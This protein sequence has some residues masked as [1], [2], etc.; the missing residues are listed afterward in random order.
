MSSP[1][2]PN[3][4]PDV[5]YVLPIR[6][7]EARP[8]EIVEVAAY[9]KSI[10]PACHQIIVADGS[11][12]EIFEAHARAWGAWCTHVQTDPHY[13]FLNGKVDGVFTG[14]DLAGT[15]KIIVGDDDVRYTPP[16]IQRMSALLD[17]H[18]YVKPQNYF[19]PLPLHARIETARMLINRAILET[20]DYPGTCGFRKSVFQRIGAY[21]GDVLFENEEMF[22]HFALNGA[23]I[24][25]A[26]DFFVR[27]LPPSL[28]KFL[29][30][31]PRQS[32]EDLVMRGKTLLFASFYPVAA[33]LGLLASRR[34]AAAYLGGCSA[35]AVGLA[36][37]GR[38]K[39]G[40]ARHFS[41]A[42]CL[43]AIPWILERG[44]SVY[45]ALFWRTTR[46]GLPYW[47]R[48][49][50]KG[51]GSQFVQGGRAALQRARHEF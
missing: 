41:A 6:R 26:D 38:A 46:G 45:L 14:T 42:S 4:P 2:Q 9:L 29:E 34:A 30:Q 8:D 12:P 3:G 15:N 27:K 23:D 13:H 17:H 1:V 49:V 22:R 5:T 11:S 10:H 28:Q 48:I 32:Y 18:D 31:R 44:V 25:C 43:F 47:G 7:A 16:Q 19:D 40:G 35:A 33:A 51:T 20:G 21:D 50:P 36:L 39:R 37:I 24:C